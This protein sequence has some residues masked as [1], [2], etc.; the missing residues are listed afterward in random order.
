M[1]QNTIDLLKFLIDTSMIFTINENGYIVFKDEPSRYFLDAAGPVSI[2]PV[3][4]DTTLYPIK[5]DDRRRPSGGEILLFRILANALEARLRMLVAHILD[6]KRERHMFYDAVYHQIPDEHHK[7]AV[8]LFGDAMTSASRPWGQVVYSRQ[9]RKAFYTE[10]DRYALAEK[11]IAAIA[12]VDQALFGNMRRQFEMTTEET[13]FP[14][15]EVVMRC[16]IAV[17]THLHLLLKDLDPE[18]VVDVAE[19]QRLFDLA[20]AELRTV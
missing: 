13:S 20:M 19:W 11:D 9:Q 10:V 7:R 4:L 17:Y 2:T 6:P 15:F 12:A 3:I 18:I 14:R 16:Y 1:S 5:E 8:K